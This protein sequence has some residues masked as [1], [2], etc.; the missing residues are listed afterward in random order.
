MLAV[1]IRYRL[2]SNRKS[3]GASVTKRNTLSENL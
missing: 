2:N 1:P 3:T